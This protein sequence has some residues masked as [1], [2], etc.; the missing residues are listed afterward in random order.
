[1]ANNEAFSA[2]SEQILAVDRTQRIYK[3]LFSLHHT[4]TI[5]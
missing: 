1:M 2:D 4:V 3:Q 5:L